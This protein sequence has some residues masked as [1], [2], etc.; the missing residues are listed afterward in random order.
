[1]VLWLL[2]WFRGFLTVRLEGVYSE[3]FLSKMAEEKITVWKLKYQKGT[4]YGKM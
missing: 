1:M 4:I 3:K 2:R